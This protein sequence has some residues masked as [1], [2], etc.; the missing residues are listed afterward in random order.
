MVQQTNFFVPCFLLTCG[1]IV[2]LVWA[3][4]SYEAA[5]GPLGQ[6]FTPSPTPG[7]ASPPPVT[8]PSPPPPLVLRLATDTRCPSGVCAAQ[9]VRTACHVN[10]TACQRVTPTEGVCQ[11]GACDAAGVCRRRTDTPEPLVYRC[12]CSCRTGAIK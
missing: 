5:L 1:T 6:H 10:A 4:A 3:A 8:P 2:L 11:L 12:D 9:P 7:P